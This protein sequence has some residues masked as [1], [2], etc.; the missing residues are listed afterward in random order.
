[1]NIAVKQ[2]S[3]PGIKTVIST[4]PGDKSI[5]HRAGIIGAL[6]DNISVF[7]HFLFSED[8]LNTLKILEALGVKIEKDVESQTVTVHGVGIN[9]FKAASS[10]LDCG[11]AG[12]GIRLLTGLLSGQPF[13]SVLTGDSSIQK[14]PMRRVIDP[15]T[16]MGAVING[17]SL[18]GKHDIYPPLTISPSTGL[19]PISYTLPVASAQ[20][21]SALLFASLYSKDTTT[22]IEPEKCRDHTE[23]ML[24]GFGAD[25]QVNGTTISCSGKKALHN[26]FTN[27][28]LIP[29][30]LSSAA[31]FLVLG[32][33]LPSCELTLTGIGLNPTRTAF[34]KALQSMGAN[35]SISNA[36]GENFEPY[37]DITIQSSSLKNIDIPHEDIPFLIDELP[38]LSTA[39]L[40]AEGTFRVRDAKELRV[41]ESDRIATIGH[42]VTAF[43]GR[44]TE[45]EDGFDIQGPEKLNE[46]VSI[47][48]FG[49]HRIAMSGVIGALAG[50]GGTI[51]DCDCIQTSFPSFISILNELGIP[52]NHG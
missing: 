22:I 18:P 3:Y 33:L 47:Q 8:C 32:A 38:I 14:R 16:H 24:Q 20:L 21:K 29:A 27:P 9:G 10:E 52:L 40:F 35:L 6:T 28:I 30:D 1:M 39:A 4:L 44:F 23:R 41:K 5:S 46:N 19:K 17:Q 15:L 7:T 45:Y 25:I 42:L 2:S 13:K 36:K 43:G 12:T 50:K 34:L 37:G 31:F 11:N 48:S 26:P 51:S 49:D